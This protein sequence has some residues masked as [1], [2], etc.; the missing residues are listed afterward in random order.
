MNE[1]LSEMRDEIYKKDDKGKKIKAIVIIVIVIAVFTTAL[2]I[3][4]KIDYN[5]NVENFEKYAKEY[6]ENNMKS[7]N[8]AS[9][10]VVNLEMLQND[11]NYDVSYFKKCDQKKTNL[12]ILVDNQ[13]NIKSTKTNIKCK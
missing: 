1:K 11:K 6:Y 2:V 3:K 4:N 8:P 7:A 9:I 10:Y 13:G 12:N 5:K